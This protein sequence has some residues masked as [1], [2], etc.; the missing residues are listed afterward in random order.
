MNKIT[1][2]YID[3]N[4]EKFK[5]VANLRFDVLFKPYGKLS[6]YDYDEDDDESFHLV[7]LSENKVVGYSRMTKINDGGR[8]TNVVVKPEFIKRGIG[9]EMMK[10]H[11]LKAEENNISNLYLNARFD[12]IE[13]YK[14]VG[15]EG[16]GN[17]FLSEK[18]GLRLQK[19]CC[20]INLK[21]DL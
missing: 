15:F 12:T 14:K 6:R 3:C 9:F 19:M 2:E 18:S 17:M 11:I 5:E 10:R 4:S 20:K 16:N 21:N 13:F 8:I 7:A 1:Y